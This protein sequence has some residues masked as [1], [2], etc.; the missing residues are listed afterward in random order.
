M[1]PKLILASS[2][3]RRVDLLKQMGIIPD[4]ISPADVDE[5]PFKSELPARY[6]QRVAIDKAKKVATI[7][8]NDVILAAD[9]T[10]VLGRRIIGKPEDDSQAKN[11][12]NLLSGRRHKVISCVA[13]AVNGKVRSKLV[14][15][16]V[17][18]KRL[19]DQEIE[20]HTDSKEWVGK[21]GGYMLQGIAG[22]FV[23]KINGSVS[24]IIGLPMYETKCLLGTTLTH[25]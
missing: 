8:P 17:Q 23:K 12:L 1:Q 19:T 7:H 20:F 10:V 24:N 2:S 4:I 6:A 22:S 25:K 16:V 18:F 3:P 13:V 14:T 15:S 9:T 11:F 5:T 21:S